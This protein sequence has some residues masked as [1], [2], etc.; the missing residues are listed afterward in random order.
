[1]NSTI[2]D[3]LE[4]ELELELELLDEELKLLDEELKLLELLELE[5]SNTTS[6]TTIVSS[7]A[8]IYHAIIYLVVPI[9]SSENCSGDPIADKSSAKAKVV[10]SSPVSTRLKSSLS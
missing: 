4:L 3:T 9:Q 1:M 6:S 8:P 10:I 5:E 7:N 2:I